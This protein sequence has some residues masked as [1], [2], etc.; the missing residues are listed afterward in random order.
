MKIYISL[1][2]SGRKIEEV[3]AEAS[4]LAKLLKQ[5]GHE[6]VNPFEVSTNE[7]A[8]YAEHM[9]KDI[10]ALLECDGA[11]FARGWQKSKGCR[12]EYLAACIYN[13]FLMGDF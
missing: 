2:I 8:S 6:P 12:L 7:N 1:P 9:G 10:Q 3:K 11:F 4:E 13:K 5:E